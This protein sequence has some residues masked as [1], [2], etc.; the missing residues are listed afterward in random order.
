ME[1]AEM[2]VTEAV[3]MVVIS[4]IHWLLTTASLHSN[5]TTISFREAL[6]SNYTTT[7]LDEQLGGM[8]PKQWLL[9]ELL[10]KLF[11]CSGLD[12]HSTKLN[13]FSQK[14]ISF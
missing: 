2:S 5:K 13:S 11:I 8:L 12:C 1:N 6:K 10:L 14:V 3:N 4:D 9:V 7:W